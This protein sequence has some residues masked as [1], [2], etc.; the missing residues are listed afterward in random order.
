MRAR[1]LLRE[2]GRIVGLT[3]TAENGES[4]TVRAESVV[5]AA[6][7]FEANPELRERHLG[8]GWQRAK[9]RGTPSTPG[10]CSPPPSP[11]ARTPTA[12]GPPA[13]VSPGTRGRRTTRATAS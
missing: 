7:G 8:A 9:V 1:D 5:L 11:R 10:T 2:G 3:W 13:T 6:G 4:G 12:T